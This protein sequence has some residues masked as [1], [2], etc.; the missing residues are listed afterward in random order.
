MS[1]LCIHISIM[2]CYLIKLKIYCL[3]NFNFIFMGLLI[4]IDYITN[5]YFKKSMKKEEDII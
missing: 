1:D 3:C 4:V 5:T 2:L